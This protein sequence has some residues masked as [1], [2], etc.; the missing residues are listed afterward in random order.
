[1]ENGVMILV[2]AVGVIMN[3]NII[4]QDGKMHMF[5]EVSFI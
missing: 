5:Q 1:M 2:E 4:L 3:L